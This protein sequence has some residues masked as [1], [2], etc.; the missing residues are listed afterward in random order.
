M[1]T[2]ITIDA[3]ELH[4]AAPRVTELHLRLVDSAAALTGLGFGVEMPPGVKGRVVGLVDAARAEVSSAAMEIDG[5]GGK[6][7]SRAGLAELA[8]RLNKIW[9]ATLPL[10][11]QLKAIGSYHRKEAARSA[12]RG[13]LA[14]AKHNRIYQLR[15]EKLSR[16]L[17]AAG[18]LVSFGPATVADVR[19]PYI[20][21]DRKIGNAA[22]R[23]GTPAALGAITKIAVSRLPFAA[24]G[25]A[26]IAVGI[27]WAVADHKL[28]LSNKIADGATWTVDKV[29]DG[30]QWFD[31]NALD[32]AGDAVS[33]GVDKVTPWDGGVPW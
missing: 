10:T 14:S 3:A 16:L 9:M 13:N 22:A 5:M 21:T 11:T 28:H 30:A 26:G 32:P 24:A 31:D 2:V 18:K 33:D 23:G 29:G 7:A 1:S 19:N 17:G 12:S 6:L 20:G 25:P 15:V 4:V 8:D 27:A